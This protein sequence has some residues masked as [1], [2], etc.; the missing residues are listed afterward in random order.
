MNRFLKIIL[1]IL[2]MQTTLT[3]AQTTIHFSR[4]SPTAKVRCASSE[5]EQLLRAQDPKRATA[6]A[7]EN[8]IAPKVQEV[9]DHKNQNQPTTIIIIPVVIHIISNGDAIGT[10]ENITDAQAMSQITILNQD[11]RKM[12]GT[13]G[14]NTN[15]VGADIEIEFC[16]AQRKPN[17]T[18]TNGIDRITKTAANY[19]TMT[20]TELMKTTT[21]WDPTQYFNIW[22]VYFSD[23]TSAEMNGTLGYAQFPSTSSLTGLNA[24]EGAA[25]HD[26]LVVDYR[27]FG[28][29]DIAPGPYFTDY[30]KGRTS[31]HEIGHCLGLLH[32]WGDVGSQSTGKDCSGTDYCADT[33][34]AGWENY[35]CN[36][37]YNSCPTDPGN[38]MVENY[39]DYTNDIC[40]NIFTLNQK[41]RITA[42]MNNSIRRA[43]LKTSSACLPLSTNQLPFFNSIQ[44]YP[45]PAQDY[46]NIKST[47]N[48][49][50]EKYMVYNSIGQ[51]VATQTIITENDQTINLTNLESGLYFVKIFK[52]NEA[53]TYRFLKK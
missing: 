36:A 47:Q 26:G 53:Q 43:S 37:I 8:W 40:M 23:T 34:N 49:L 3:F 6:A 45:N 48:Q 42:V 29:V 9:L 39:M 30:D 28:S 33:P 19:A 15:P 44:L 13:N 50:P 22:T 38:D 7:F 35:D 20:A 24:N 1:T 17:G 21:Q 12:F 41:A 31:T 52:N 27:C 11:F 25:N 10:N 2:L 14:Y 46:I 16:L 18:A 5:Y 4:K 32:V 51:L